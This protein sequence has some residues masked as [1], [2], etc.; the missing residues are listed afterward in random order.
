MFMK[1]LIIVLFVMLS[2]PSWSQ[3]V[4]IYYNVHQDSIWYMKNGKSITN[5]EIKK[6]NMVYFHLVEFN[7]YLY[8]GTDQSND[9]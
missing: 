1:N 4:H 2:I 5:L 6:D 7:N 9:S 8:K 3:D